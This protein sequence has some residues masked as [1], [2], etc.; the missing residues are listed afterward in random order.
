MTKLKVTISNEAGVETGSYIIECVDRPGLNVEE[1]DTLYSLSL[2]RAAAERH[3][4]L[5]DFPDVPPLSMASPT[6]DLADPIGAIHL[7][8]VN[9]LWLEIH[10]LMLGARLNFATSRVLKHLEDEHQNQTHFD[11]NARFDLHL[12]KM[13]RFHLAVFEMARI[14]DLIVRTMYEYFGDQFIQV[15][16][17]EE[18][19]EKRL[20]W[21]RMKDALNKRGKPE[22]HPHPRLEAMDDD[23]YRHLL[24]LIRRYRSPEVLTLIRYRDIRTHR[25]APSVDHPE[26]AV[27]V[28]PVGRAINSDKPVPLFPQS[29]EAQFQFAELYECAKKVYAQMLHLLLGLGEIIHA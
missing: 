5:N 27:D 11:V 13:E 18:N 20:T 29:S 26:L 14:E 23:T 25:V 16:Y 24:A 9:E 3:I 12:E 8:N 28:L 2:I 19:W 6:F 21:D 1:Y 7:K 17:S 4:Y 15:D 10:N 22:Q